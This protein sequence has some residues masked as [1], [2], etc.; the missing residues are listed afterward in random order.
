MRRRQEAQCRP[1]RQPWRELFAQ[2]RPTV[3]LVAEVEQVYHLQNTSTPLACNATLN[4]LL[5]IDTLPIGFL[6]NSTKAV[7]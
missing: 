1:A 3:A 2:P 4:V 7:R 5:S 6:K